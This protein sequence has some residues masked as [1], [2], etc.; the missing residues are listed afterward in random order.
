[1]AVEPTASLEAAILLNCLCSICW[2]KKGAQSWT[3][4]YML[5]VMVWRVSVILSFASAITTWCSSLHLNYKY[6]YYINNYYLTN[7]CI[8]PVLSRSL[9][10][11]VS[12][13]LVSSLF[14]LHFLLDK[15]I[16]MSNLFNTARRHV[17]LCDTTLAIT[18]RNISLFFSFFLCLFFFPFFHAKKIK[19]RE[20][21]R[22]VTNGSFQ[23]GRKSDDWIR[24]VR[25]GF[26]MESPTLGIQT[27]VLNRQTTVSSVELLVN[28]R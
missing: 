9:F 11:S 20:F 8:S 6:K 2:N 26:K 7:T 16:K 3:P 15:S 4:T 14:I 1:M 27:F 22:L 19:F 24:S 17:S 23:N 21:P 13:F 18:N 28:S 12:L 5:P 10:L 25:H